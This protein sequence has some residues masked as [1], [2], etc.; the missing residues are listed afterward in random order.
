[1][2]FLLSKLSSPGWDKEFDTE[3]EAVIEL[4]KHICVTCL[5][6][7]EYV[8]GENGEPVLVEEAFPDWFPSKIVDVEYDGELFE[9]KDPMILLG[10]PCGCEFSLEEL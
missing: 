4:R 1:M 2:R 5:K 10:T 8:V 3:L 7:E 6:G 9:C